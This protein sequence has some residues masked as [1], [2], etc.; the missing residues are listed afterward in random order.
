[1]KSLERSNI[2][3]VLTSVIPLIGGPITGYLLGRKIRDFEDSLVYLFMGF[4]MFVLSSSI[5]SFIYFRNYLYLV[6]IYAAISP[7]L[8][9]YIISRKYQ[10]MQ[11]NVNEYY[12]EIKLEVPIDLEENTDPNIIF[13]K[14]FNKALKKMK[15]P[16]YYYKLKSLNSCSNLKVS[17]SE[18]KMILRRR[19]GDIIIEIELTNNNVADMKVSISY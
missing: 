12:I 14:I 2:L 3:I 1:M 7:F 6:L 4:P 10:N 5:L 15:N 13:E 19:C 11:I 9:T 18:N 8:V 17:L 16:Y